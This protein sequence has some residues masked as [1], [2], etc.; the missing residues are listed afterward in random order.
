MTLSIPVQCWGL[1]MIGICICNHTLKVYIDF[2]KC[3]LFI[4][5]E[6]E[7]WLTQIYSLFQYQFSRTFDPIYGKK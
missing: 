1:K 3:Q 4:K 7:T 2:I 5:N 6:Y